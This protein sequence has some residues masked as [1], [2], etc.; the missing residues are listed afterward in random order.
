M[1]IPMHGL[2]RF[3]GT[4]RGAAASVSKALGI[5]LWVVLF[6]ALFSLISPHFMSFLNLSNVTR[7]ASIFALMAT[8][9][10]FVIISGGID[11]SVGSIVSLTSAVFG[12]VWRMT[13][14]L[15]LSIAAGM[16]VGLLSGSTVGVLV[17]FLEIPPFIATFGMM[18]IGAGIAFAVTPSSISGF[19]PGFEFL[20]NGHI[21]SVPFPVLIAAAIGVVF[22]L[23]LRKTRLGLH[24]LAAG[25]S[26][27]SALM[28][29]INVRARKLTVYVVNGALA[30]LAGIILCA[31]IRSSYPGIGKDLE[32]DVIAMAVIGGASLVG[33]Y[34]SVVGALGGALFLTMIQNLFNLVGVYPFL[35][36]VITGALIVV[37]VMANQSRRRR[38]VHSLGDTS[39]DLVQSGS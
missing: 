22:H 7:Q 26:E 9:M 13:N 19:P 32:L 31:R 18:G 28:A 38:R 10:T 1:A 14:N 6:A 15:A 36:K 39:K 17:G 24:I 2:T 34:G 20:G 27:S 4:V 12:V 25:G 3:A 8:G 30:S 37:A 23:L 11:L 5:W 35:Q 29:G 21:L 16:M 33:G